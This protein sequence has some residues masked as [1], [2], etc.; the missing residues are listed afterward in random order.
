MAYLKRIVIPY[1]AIC[2]IFILLQKIKFKQPPDYDLLLM[3]SNLYRPQVN[4]VFHLWFL[5]VLTQCLVML[6]LVFSIKKLRD[7]FR[8]NLCDESIAILII[9]SIFCF[10]I[11]FYWDTK[12]ISFRLPYIFLP[13]ILFG[14]FTFFSITNSIKLIFFFFFTTRL[15]IVSSF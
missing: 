6:G 1:M 2:I 3:V 12:Y 8:D 5:Q 11:N 14:L 9:F 10:D 15:I 7:Y 13:L 4:A